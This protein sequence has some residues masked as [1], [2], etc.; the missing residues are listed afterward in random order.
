MASYVAT[1]ISGT[2]N[3]LNAAR[4]NGPRRVVVTSTSECYGTAR[5]APIDEQ[6]PL[7]GQS[8]YSATKIGADK[9]A[10]SFHLSFGVP[11]ATI[12]PFNTYGPRQSARAVIPSVIAQALAGGAVKV[13][14]LT[15]LRDFN[16]VSDTVSG[17]LRVAESDAATGE[18]INIGSGREV[19]IG[20]IVD[21]VKTLVGR[22]FAVETEDARV[23]PEQSEV[24]RLLCDRSKAERL[25][26][27]TPQVSLE[28]GLGRT[29]DYIRDH[30]A[31]YHTERYAV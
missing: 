16:Y 15:P 28:E 10:E 13:G 24:M 26:G 8:P 2:L 5:Y 9:L 1:N 25:L 31:L 21:R 3:I 11:V 20:D 7:Q 6:H 27:W 22:D 30:L 4:A 19:S 14:S 18:V 23:R 29:V 12:R 17:F